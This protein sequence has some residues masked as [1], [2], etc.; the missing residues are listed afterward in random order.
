M[1]KY[2]NNIEYN[3]LTS[4]TQEDMYSYSNPVV[5]AAERKCGVSNILANKTI[6]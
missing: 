3:K 4:E 2:A 5:L 1:L 6:E